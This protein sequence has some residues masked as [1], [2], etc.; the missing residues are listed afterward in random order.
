M[1]TSKFGKAFAE[2]RKA[3]GPGKTFTFEGKSYST[4]MASDKGSAPKASPRPTARPAKKAPP[5]KGRPDSAAR[6]S[7]ATT[8]DRRWADA[9]AKPKAETAKPKVEVKT[10]TSSTT[11]PQSRPTGTRP[12][13]RPTATTPVAKSA[14]VPSVTTTPLAPNTLKGYTW[15]QYIKGNNLGRLRAGVP[16]DIR[17][18]EDFLK[19][20]A[21]EASAKNA[22]K[23]SSVATR[24]ANRGQ[25][26]AKGGMVKKSNCGASVPPS[27]KR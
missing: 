1:A 13:S 3:K 21:E 5:M 24:R 6:V 25:S 10:P 27:K 18:E 19:K 16:M 4:N 15:D 26:Y 7:D 22:P 8:V 11:R 20:A 12:Q 23:T 17:S 14:S 9:N 2:A